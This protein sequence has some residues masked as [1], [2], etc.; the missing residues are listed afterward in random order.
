MLRDILLL[1]ETFAKTQDELAWHEV[2][3]DIQGL[4]DI[5]VAAAKKN[6]SIGTTFP[7]LAAIVGART[8]TAERGVATKQANKKAK[9][10]PP[11]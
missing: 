1:R 2:L 7:A 6:P 5:F 3:S 10:A 8:L 4:H 11:K 9:A